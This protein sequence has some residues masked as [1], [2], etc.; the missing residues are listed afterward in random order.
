M[1]NWLVAFLRVNLQDVRRL[2]P[3]MLRRHWN[4]R[5]RPGQVNSFESRRYGRIWYRSG[6]ED[7]ALVRVVLGEEFYAADWPVPARER[8]ERAYSAILSRGRRPV[9]VNGGG[10][11][12]LSAI[13]FARAWPEAKVVSIEPDPANLELLRGNLDG[14]AGHTI[15]AAAL[16][17]TPGSVVLDR[18]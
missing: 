3:G 13:W 18:E 11:I 6:S 15:I 14:R 9:I 4:D 16:G 7:L 5:R 1:L 10:Y 12:G 2:G 8:L 17:S